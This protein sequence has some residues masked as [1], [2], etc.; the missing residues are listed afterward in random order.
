MMNQHTWETNGNKKKWI[1][2]SVAVVR[3]Q[4]D[5]CVFAIVVVVAAA[6]KTCMVFPMMSHIV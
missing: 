4:N 3:Q 2:S 1:L 5:V 6:N